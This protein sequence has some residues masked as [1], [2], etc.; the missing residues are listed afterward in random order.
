MRS[1]IYDFIIRVTAPQLEL[2]PGSKSVQIL[3]D[4][5]QGLAHASSHC[6]A[7]WLLAHGLLKLALA[8]EL[9]QGKTWWQTVAGRA[10]SP[11]TLLAI[12]G[13]SR[14]VVKTGIG[15][16]PDLLIGRCLVLI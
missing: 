14:T 16:S 4:G 6:I 13:C 3:R 11:T 15:A 12:I 10:L 9:L 8:I 5:A 2:H 7:I 1:G